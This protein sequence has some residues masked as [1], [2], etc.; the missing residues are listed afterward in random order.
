MGALN[1]P[2]LTQDNKALSD[3]RTFFAQT[4]AKICTGTDV[5]RPSKS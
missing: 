2:N 5:S 3:V 1:R 4:D